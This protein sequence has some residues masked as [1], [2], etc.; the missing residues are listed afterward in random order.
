MKTEEI[1]KKYNN[2]LYFFILKKTK[3]KSI[4]NDVLQNT[5]LKIH[6]NITKLNS[7]EKAKPWSFQIAR[8]EIANYYNKEAIYVENFNSNNIVDI[9]QV[10]NYCCFDSF[11]NTL[12]TNYRQVIELIY[13]EGF[14]QK[15]VASK[16]AIS[17][18]NVKARV[19]R[20]KD[21]LKDNFSKCCKY[22]FNKQG[23]LI[24]EANCAMCKT[25]D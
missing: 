1:W 2:E 9:K 6:K 20:A 8:N 12:P 21:I 17:L 4:T 11:I 10:D 25:N 22:Q 7:D 24:G 15:E 19:R 5:F 14:K 13:V 23:K 18:D 3:D 16:L